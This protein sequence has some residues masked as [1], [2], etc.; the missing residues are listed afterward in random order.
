MKKKNNKHRGLNFFLAILSVLLIFLGT[1]AFFSAF[2]Y[3]RTFGDTG[4]DSIVFTL[5]SDFHSTSSNIMS[6]YFKN[7]LIPAILVTALIS[8]LVFY[9]SK[10]A[11]VLSAFSK[12]FR[13]YPLGKTS[14]K[15]VS[16]ILCITLF[17]LA[18]GSVGMFDYIKNLS[19]RTKIYDEYYVD[20][21]DTDIKFPET[22]RNLIYIFLESMETSFFSTD[23]GGAL[24]YNTIPELY[25]LAK[26]NTNFSDNSSVGGALAVE[27]SGWTVAGM[28]SQTAGIPLYLPGNLG[29]ND[30]KKY[31]KFLPGV[32]TLSNILSENG[33]NQ[34]LMVGSD[35]NFGGRRNLY[36][37]HGTDTIHDLFSIKEDGLI[38]EDYFVNWGFE[39]S[40]LF[41]FSKSKILDMAKSDKPFAYTLLTVDT[42]FPSGYKCKLCKNQFKNKYENVFACS[43]R[44]VSAFVDWIKK[45]DFYEN[46]TVIIS[47]DHCTMDEDYASKNIPSNYTRHVYNCF[48]NSAVSTKNSKNRDFTTL[49]MFPTTLAAMG[50]EI[51]GDRLGL[52]TNLFSKTKTLTEEKGFDWLNSET[53]KSSKYYMS[54]FLNNY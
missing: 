39:D 37:Q 23:K 50:C 4:F 44:L 30:Y 42:H 15:V 20:P 16:V 11:I 12:K 24:P 6:S 51:K 7:G 35:S 36:L 47:G 31:T 48:I 13:L 2:W 40:K 53:K 17:A 19:Q 33:Y 9:K 38:P 34:A 54:R 18:G 43:S 29:K 8:F 10:F 5:L 28:V 3:L 46:T 22:K 45:Q 25:N 49:D 14:T 32:T 52:G 26:S 1:T 21:K 41:E 27:R